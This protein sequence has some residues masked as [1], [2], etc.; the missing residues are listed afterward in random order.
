MTGIKIHGGILDD[1]VV[2][3]DSESGV[4]ACIIDVTYRKDTEPQVKFNA[5]GLNSKLGERLIWIKDA[6]LTIG[7]KLSFEIINTDNFTQSLKNKEMSSDDVAK[8]KLDAYHKLKAELIAE[9]LL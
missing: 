6:N 1:L 9:G 3:L 4:I 8:K 7:D 5:T 2:G